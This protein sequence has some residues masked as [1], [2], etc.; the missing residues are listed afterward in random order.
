MP[1]Y[2]PPDVI[3][4]SEHLLNYN[5]RLFL[6]YSPVR[7]TG[8]FDTNRRTSAPRPLYQFHDLPVSPVDFHYAIPPGYDI[9]AHA[10]TLGRLGTTNRATFVSLIITHEHCQYDLFN[11]VRRLSNGQGQENPPRKRVN[12][13]DIAYPPNQQ[14]HGQ[15]QS[16]LSLQSLREPWNNLPLDPG[17]H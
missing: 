4:P 7:T 17:R 10:R 14:P 5:V 3:G 9:F 16:P 2:S 6:I 8:G 15:P 1:L 12:Q 13:A 11:D